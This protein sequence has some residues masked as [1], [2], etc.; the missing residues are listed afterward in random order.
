MP[1]NKRQFIVEYNDNRDTEDKSEQLDRI[2]YGVI[3]Y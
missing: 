1:V 2:V 3:L